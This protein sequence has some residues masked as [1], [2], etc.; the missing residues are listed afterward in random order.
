MEEQRNAT[1]LANGGKAFFVELE[2]HMVLYRDYALIL[3]VHK[4][5]TPLSRIYYF[6]QL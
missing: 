6:R 3:P 4:V 1:V 5:Q 2:V